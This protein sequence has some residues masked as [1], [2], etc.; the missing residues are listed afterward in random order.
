MTRVIFYL[1]TLVIGTLSANAQQVTGRILDSETKESIPFATIKVGE[2]D[3]ISNNDG[4]FTL[5]GQN[6]TDSTLLSISFIGYVPQKISVSDLKSKNNIIYLAQGSYDLGGVYVSNVKPDPNEIIKL[7]NENL[8]A[9]YKSSDYKSTIFIRESNTFTPKNFELK[10]KKSTELSKSEVREINKEVE[11][12]ISK[13][14]NTSTKTYSDKLLDVY[15][16]NLEPKLDVK[17]A[18]QLKD[19]NRSSGYDELQES[20]KKIFYTVMDTTKFYR[21]KSGLIG[22]KDTI[23]FS[24]EYNKN[25]NDSKKDKKESPH[26]KNTKSDIKTIVNQSSFS[27]TYYTVSNAYYIDFIKESE[28]YTYDY[29]EATYLDDNLVYVIDFKPRKSKAR[30]SGRLYINESD[31]AIVRADYGLADGKKLKGINLKLLL[32]V[33][34][35]EGLKKGVVIY[36]KNPDTDTYYLQYSLQERETYFYLNRPVKFI[37]LTDGK[38]KDKIS[39][40]IKIEGNNF[41]KTE[42]LNISMQSLSKSDYEAFQEKEFEYQILKKYDPNIWKDYNVIEPLEEMKKFEVVE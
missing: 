31:Y 19:E 41:D 15:M 37:E 14:I 27:D 34:L 9:N 29:V 3:L 39:Y 32:G 4:Y 10:L 22:S 28:L 17:K 7:V 11:D 26:L 16:L 18:I 25:K 1:F 8:S 24:K 5:S 21:I 13:T 23:S 20:S 33:K 30:Y 6:A 35:Q 36:K 42:Y 2:T 40:N 38:G 12:L